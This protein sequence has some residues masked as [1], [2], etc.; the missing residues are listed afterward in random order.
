MTSK[1]DLKKLAV[2]N[3]ISVDD[4]ARM[5]TH[6]LKEHLLKLG[7]LNNKQS[8]SAEKTETKTET[9]TVVAVNLDRPL[10]HDDLK[11]P[12]QQQQYQQYQ[13]DQV[14][15]N[16]YQLKSTNDNN[17]AAFYNLKSS[18]NN[19]NNLYQF[20]N[21]DLKKQSNE[22]DYNN[23]IVLL[24]TTP[25]TNVNMNTNTNIQIVG[26]GKSSTIDFPYDITQIENLCSKSDGRKQLRNG[27]KIIF[28]Q[29]HIITKKIKKQQAWLQTDAA[30]LLDDEDREIFFTSD[31]EPLH[32]QKLEAITLVREIGRILAQK[33][34]KQQQVHSS[35][36]SS[37]GNGF[38]E[39][40]K[41][42]CAEMQ[43]MRNLVSKFLNE[44]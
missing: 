34:N 42:K 16:E 37:T 5:N 28:Q 10:C 20:I 3:G 31:I 6:S 27:L 22:E 35:I 14:K 23:A 2:L 32:Q 1:D 40:W 17:S 11:Q 33:V 13:Q 19:T 26:G 9:K 44:M 43:A 36:T 4:V 7:L 25:Q 8:S 29:C 12:M 39:H 18:T 21:E 41:R 15:K 38:I 24:D 30:Q